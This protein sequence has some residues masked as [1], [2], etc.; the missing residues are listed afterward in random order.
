MKIRILNDSIRLRLSQTEVRQLAEEGLVSARTNFMELMSDRFVYSVEKN[1]S[2]GI[3]ASF[4]GGHMRIFAN[5]DM[6]DE[7]ASTDRIS[8]KE[9][10][11]PLRITIEKDFKCKTDRG[12]DESDLFPNGNEHC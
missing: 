4:E 8:M 10:D 7:W 3:G 5:Q 12:E 11:R 9:E 1:G 2:E 6:V